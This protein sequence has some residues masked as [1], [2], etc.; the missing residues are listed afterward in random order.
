M[1]AGFY[2]G[3]PEP[4]ARKIALLT[5][6]GF[7]AQCFASG[8]GSVRTAGNFMPL[9]GAEPPPFPRNTLASALYQMYISEVIPEYNIFLSIIIVGLCCD[10]RRHE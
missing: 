5:P 6:A 10:Q 7:A 2:L 1:A 9:T 8:S 3:F 4:K